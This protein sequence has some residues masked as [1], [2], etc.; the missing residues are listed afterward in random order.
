MKFAMLFPGQG[1]QS[2]GMLNAW[3]EASPAVRETIA[4]ACDVLGDELVELLSTGPS[5][6]L[7]KTE[8]TQPA[9]LIADVALWRAWLE[10]G[11][12]APVA[13]AG[14]SLGEY[15][16]MVAAGV[17]SFAEALPLVRE[18]ALAMRDA[19]PDGAGAMAAVVGLDA[20]AVADLCAKVSGHIEPVNFNAPT[21]IVIAGEAAAI[22]EVCGRAKEFG[23]RMI[24]RL[25]VSVPAHSRMMQAARDRLAT[26]M[27]AID[28][29]AAKIPVVQ[30]VDAQA[31]SNVVELQATLLDQVHS[32]VRWVDTQQVLLD[33]FGCTEA[34][35]CGPGNVLAGLGR[36]SGI[37]LSVTAFPAPESLQETKE[38]FAA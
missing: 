31:H 25:P 28:F 14:H 3:S 13:V 35:E 11:G 22:D 21:Q 23:A 16:A 6:K 18:R 4:E 19:V 2:V 7:D 29:Q 34:L 26:A 37:D 5:C 17:L 15:S 1:S 20:A 12:A 30:N 9:M 33:Q 38:R 10:A 27:G 36:R 32:A 24:R 8:N